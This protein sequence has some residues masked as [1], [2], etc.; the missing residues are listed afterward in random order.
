MTRKPPGVT[1]LCY[2][3]QPQPQTHMFARARDMYTHTRAF[4]RI[5]FMAILRLLS[6][7]GKRA[8]TG[9]HR[10]QHL[11]LSRFPRGLYSIDLFGMTPFRFVVLHRQ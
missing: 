10:L 11:V 8:Y 2:Y 4:T 9:T 1:S 3:T 6:R 7:I 5:L